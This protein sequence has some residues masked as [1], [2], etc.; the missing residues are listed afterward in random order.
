M[1]TSVHT[2]L[3]TPLRRSPEIG[4]I[5]RRRSSVLTR[6]GSLLPSHTHTQTQSGAHTHSHTHARALH[7]LRKHT[8]TY[9]H[10]RT[11]TLTRARTRTTCT[12]QTRTHIHT[13]WRTYSLTHARTHIHVHTH[14]HTHTTTTTTTQRGTI[15]LLVPQEELLFMMKKTFL[16]CVCL[17][18]TVCLRAIP[19]RL[20]GW[21]SSSAWQKH[22]SAFNRETSPS[23]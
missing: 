8:H 7:A 13:H 17:T 15:L 3:A 22:V 11:H 18:H 2:G 5:G 1:V 16:V 19:V 12:A 20:T 23:E 9:T 4:K 10:R 21:L 6:Q 14:T